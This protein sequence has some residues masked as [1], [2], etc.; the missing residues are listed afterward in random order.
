MIEPKPAQTPDAARPDEPSSPY[1]DVQTTS[2]DR[3][4]GKSKNS[5][6]RTHYWLYVLAMVIGAGLAVT[7]A[8]LGN[9]KLINVG[10]YVLLGSGLLWH[11]AR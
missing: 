1:Y 4:D 5:T 6:W 8:L 7:G 10:W 9:D 11:F 2:Y 3:V